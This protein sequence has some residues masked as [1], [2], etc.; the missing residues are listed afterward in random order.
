MLMRK[1]NAE[2]YRVTAEVRKKAGDGYD[3]GDG[4]LYNV[5]YTIK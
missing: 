1:T 3:I 5:R 4:R 2:E